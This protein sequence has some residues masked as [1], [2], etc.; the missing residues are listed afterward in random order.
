MTEETSTLQDFPLQASIQAVK[1]SVD[2]E[3]YE[4]FYHYLLEH[5]PQNSPQTRQRYAELVGRR[6]FP[7]LSLD[8]LLPHVWRAYQDERILVDLMRVY[9]LEAEPVIARFVMDKVWPL[10][11]G[12]VFDLTAARAFVQETYGTFK[13]KSYERLL[14]T[15]RH[16]GFLGRYD[17]ELVT[18]Q[19]P[20]P[21]DA[22]LILMHDRL[23][24]TPRI[25]RLN[26]ILKADWW[27]Y[28]GIKQAD[29]VRHVLRRA[30][31]TGL[32]SRYAAVDELE[33]VTTRF[34]LDEYITQAKRL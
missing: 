26:E 20:M 11:V 32:I 30:E 19:V 23:A 33:Q 12:Q 24:P 25:V 6:Y 17:G 16:L 7:G 18:E 14:L 31:A 34:A 8:N 22:L 13:K 29:D 27:R 28:L 3:S 15:V 5:L 9:A 1:V 2:F 21:A 4:E 10:S